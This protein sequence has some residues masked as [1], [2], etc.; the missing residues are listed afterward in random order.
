[1]APHPLINQ[2]VPEFSIPDANGHTF[3]FPPEE[4]GVRVKK[5]IALFFYPE[6]GTFGC[7][8]EACQF[9]DAL[10]EKEIFKRTDVQVIGISPDPVPKQKQ[11]VESQ[12][13]TYPVLSDEKHVAYQAFHVGKSLLGFTDTRTTFVID[14][15]GIIRD[16][17]SATMN[18]SA[19]VKFVIKA[20]GK[21]E[22]DSSQHSGESSSKTHDVE[23][24]AVRSD[25]SSSSQIRDE[26]G[27]VAYVVGA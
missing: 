2:P 18:Y 26:L 10:V 12:S 7:I 24:D 14:S 1:M 4:Q 6:A 8:R 19:H 27:R 9:R 3:K 21:L 23:D 17:L 11:F 5:P 13:L 22:V 25:D 15:E 16:S 20:L